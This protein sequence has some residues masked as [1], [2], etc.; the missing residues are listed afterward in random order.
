ME[1]YPN[2]EHKRELITVKRELENKWVHPAVLNVYKSQQL[3]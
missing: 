1:K 2:F 3:R